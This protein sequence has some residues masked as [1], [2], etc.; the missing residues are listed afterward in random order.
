MEKEQ[1]KE[2]LDKNYTVMSPALFRNTSLHKIL[3]SAYRL[4]SKR[5]M[6]R[7]PL[8]FIKYT[9]F[10][11]IFHKILTV[12]IRSIIYVTFQVFCIGHFFRKLK[13]FHLSYM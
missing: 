1:I 10:Q 11:N 6:L 9:P 7:I 3:S 13:K 4:G 12:L 2:K 5:V 8:N